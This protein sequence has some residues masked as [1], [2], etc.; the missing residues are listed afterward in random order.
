MEAGFCGGFMAQWFMAALVR[1]PG[2][3][4]FG[5][6]FFPLLKLLSLATQIDFQ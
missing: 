1:H 6:Q 4:F 2:Y 3:K 5:Y